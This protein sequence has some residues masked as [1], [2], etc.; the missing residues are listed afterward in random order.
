MGNVRLPLATYRLQFNS[1]F[2]FRDACRLIPY[3]RRLGI[4]ELYAS[5]LFKAR[6][7]S[8]HGYDV[9]DPNSL[10]PEL[11][12]EPD[13]DALIQELQAHGLGLLLDTV[14]NHMAASPENPWWAH[15]L[16]YGPASPYAAF[17]DIDWSPPDSDLE[18][19]ILLPILSYP[20]Q[21]ALERGEVSLTWEPG[22]P[23]I[24]YHSLRLPLEVKSYSLILGR[25]LGDTNPRSRPVVMELE[26]LL[27]ALE[28]LPPYSQA[29]SDWQRRKGLKERLLGLVE[30]HPEVEDSLLRCL[31]GL[32][33]RKGEPDSIAFLEKILA[34]QVYRLCF[35]QEGLARLNYRRFFDISDLAG[36]RAQ[37]PRVLEATH[38]LVLRLAGEGKAT[39]LRIDHVD[40]LYDPQGYLERLQQRLA[41]DEGETPDRPGFYIIVEKIL[42]REETLPEEWPVYG[43]TGYD[44]LDMLNRL[45]IPD[46]GLR[47]LETIHDRLTGSNLRFA[48][49]VCRKKHQVMETL[50][51][52]EV[53]SL[54][55]HLHGLALQDSPT[56]TPSLE[57]LAR[58][59]AAVTASLPVYRTYIRSLEVSARDRHCLERA[60]QDAQ[61]RDPDIETQA[62]AFLRRVLLL[63]FPRT[64]GEERRAAWLQFVMRW[65]QNTGPVMAKGLEDTAL[66]NYSCLVSL[67]EVGGDPDM[68]AFSVQDFHRRNRERGRRRPY[69]LNATA[70]HDTK[71]GE[72][73]R[74]RINVLAEMPHEWER[75]FS[76]WMQWNAPWKRALQGQPV[77]GPDMELLIY[78]MLLGAWPLAEEEIAPFKGRFRAYLIKAA[79]EAKT[80]TSWLAP[81]P[82]YEEA[83]LSFLEAILGNSEENAFLQSFLQF[84]SH[85]AFYGAINGLA[86]I[87]LK[88][89][90]PG[91]PDFYQGTELWD[92]SLVDPDNRRPVDFERRQRLLE[93]LTAGESRGQQALLSDLLTSWKDGRV[94]LYVVYKALNLRH[95]YRQVFQDSEYVMLSIEGER[96]DNACAF[97]RR[98]GDSWTLVVVPRFPSRLVKP[99]CWPLGKGAWGGS[100]I[101]L[102]PGAPASW[103]NVFTGETVRA[104]PATGR[105]YLCEILDSFPVA[106]LI[107]P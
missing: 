24:S 68:P 32:R 86:Q 8:P 79:R 10:N 37:D 87:L 25:C 51:P 66:Y 93:G 22:G 12:G 91:V 2:G 71:R 65:Q 1:R 88:V 44:F 34:C 106:L 43:T 42:A 3:L 85:I 94:K 103:R 107:A 5:P 41:G 38:A 54:A 17:F 30:R 67:N 55:C 27:E 92:L 52:A 28:A 74:A 18:N 82:A 70:T 35:W 15:V 7:G 98:R 50:F 81:D 84:Q 26:R 20:Y 48:D 90:S 9:L 53:R 39:G 99:G 96:R 19:H 72:D 14:P 61:R 23:F 102:P 45:F 64:L 49:V 58:A 89:A 46:E 63:E 36:V 47:A 69:T 100:S 31:A 29:D 73:V 40:G 97:A 59:L 57:A 6:P 13:F 16:E 78:Q 83:L 95:Y 77:P 4:T 80:F 101:S 11:G 76:R 105:L 21:E 104:S 56:P 60:F 62:L 33:Q 75:Q